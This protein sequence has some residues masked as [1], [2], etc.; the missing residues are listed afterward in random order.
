MDLRWNDDHTICV[1]KPKR[2]KKITGTRLASIFG[3]NAWS[4]PF[5]TWCEV[6]RTYEEPFED[7]IYTLAGKVIE[8]KQADYVEKH[9]VNRDFV[10]PANIWGE[11]YFKKTFGDFFPNWSVFGGMWDYVDR[12]PVAAK[13]RTVYEMKTTKRVEDWQD[14]VPEYYALQAALYAYLLDCDNVMMVVSFLDEQYY[15]HPEDFVPN[16]SNTMCKTFKLSQR[17]P[18]FHED[19]ILPALDWYNH[20]VLTGISPEYD[21]V[22]DADILKQLR[23]IKPDTSDGLDSL[24]AEAEG[25]KDELSDEYARIKEKEDRYDALISAIKDELVRKLGTDMDYA[26]VTGRRYNFK[27]SKNMK[28]QIDRKA[29][30]RDGIL[31]KYQST[32]PYFS[33]TMKEVKT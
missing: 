23:T 19:Y 30:E 18:H 8:P 14:D 1:P 2:P 12:D 33:L 27:V 28:T 22:K 13:V 32:S 25:L 7:T 10:R 3:L 11:D 5:K 20:H 24:I 6:T 4:T 9:F 15:E 26:E 21:E 16:P 17:Y 31:D 29:M